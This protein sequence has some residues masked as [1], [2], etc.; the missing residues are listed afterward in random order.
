M[1]PTTF[2]QLSWVDPSKRICPR[3]MTRIPRLGRSGVSMLLRQTWPGL[4]EQ[5]FMVRRLH[6]GPLEQ[7]SKLVSTRGSSCQCNVEKQSKL[8]NHSEI[9]LQMFDTIHTERRNHLLLLC[10]S[11]FFGPQRARA[12]AAVDPPVKSRRM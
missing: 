10:I 2:C 1:T 7:L 4:T 11:V 6:Q 9:Y 8:N 3:I 12:P 5:L